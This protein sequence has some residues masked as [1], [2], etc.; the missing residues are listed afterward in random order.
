LSYRPEGG[1]QSRRM[2]APAMA[3]ADELAPEIGHLTV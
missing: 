2:I 1:P 3:K